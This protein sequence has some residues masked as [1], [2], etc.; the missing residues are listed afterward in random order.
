M[1]SSASAAAAAIDG[2]F[3]LVKRLTVETVGNWARFT[4]RLGRLAFKRRCFG[5]LGQWLKAIKA[6][7]RIAKDDGSTSGRARGADRRTARR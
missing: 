3:E 4:S 7:E 5:H 6:G 1:A 2:G